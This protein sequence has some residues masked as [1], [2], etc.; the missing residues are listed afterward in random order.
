MV[1]IVSNAGSDEYSNF[2]DRHNIPEF[3][4]VY[5]TIHHLSNTE[6]VTKVME[7]IVSVILLDAQLKK[8]TTTGR[9][10]IIQA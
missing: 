1:Q 3:T 7:W 8:T 10:L 2:F 6:T 9:I 5:H 4:K